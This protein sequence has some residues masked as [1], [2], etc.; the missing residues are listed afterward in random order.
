MKVLVPL[1]GIISNWLITSA[2]MWTIAIQFT[3]YISGI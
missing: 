3:L 2:S 1:R